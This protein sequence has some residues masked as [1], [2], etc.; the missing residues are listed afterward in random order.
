MSFAVPLLGLETEYGIVRE[1]LEHSDPVEESMALLQQC[2]IKNVFRA[3]AYGQERTHFD[4]RGFT[5]SHLAQDDE[6][7][8][9][10]EQD[11]Q[12]PY[13]YWEMKSDRVLVNGARFYNDHTHPEYS[14]PECSGVF[15]LVAHD[16]AG[17][18]I[19]RDCVRRRNAQL[20]G[21]HLQVFKNNT[22]YSG[23]SYGTH[24]NYLVSR[25]LPFETWVRYLVPF[26]VTRQLYAG[27]GKVGADGKKV[28]PFTGLQLGQR[29]DFIECVLS[30]ETMT[31]R[32]IINTRDEPHADTTAYRRLHLILGDANMSPYATALKVGTTRLVLALIDAENLPPALELD[33]P[34]HDV[35]RVSRD[36]TGTVLLKRAGG[37]TITPLEIQEWYLEQAARQM[38]VL[39]DPDEANWIVK[40]WQRTLGDLKHSPEKLCD[41][42]DWAIK[43]SLFRDFMEAE[44]VG[45]DDPLMQSLDL[46]YHNLDPERGLYYGLAASGEVAPFLR[47]ETVDRAVHNAPPSTRARL[48]GQLVD[49]AGDDIRSIHWTGVEFKNGDYLDLTHIIHPKDVEQALSANKEL[50]AWK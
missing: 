8:E 45:W 14:T 44:G 24:D 13:S 46:E 22:D 21:P 19:V 4:L 40:E 27:A 41:R 23:H 33:D 12:R 39:D 26:L 47:D 9:F 31:Q 18:R 2:E 17:D 5:V 30:I 28:E 16:Q 7:D 6:E 3:W 43:E 50:F 48:R 20:G 42:I 35:Q 1:D 10:C 37:G 49:R 34:V 25:R 36:R 38:G 29:S 32:P 11:K 15:E